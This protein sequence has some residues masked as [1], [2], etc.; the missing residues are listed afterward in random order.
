MFAYASSLVKPIEET[1]CLTVPDDRM[2]TLVDLNTRVHGNRI[3]PMEPC[4][5]SYSSAIMALPLIT[6][7]LRRL[8]HLAHGRES[9][10]QAPE[11][12]IP[13]IKVQS[14][15]DLATWVAFFG[16]LRDSRWISDDEYIRRLSQLRAN[17]H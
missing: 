16:R 5:F 3:L 14:Q 17:S 12:G 1:S 15:K 2:L 4:T 9:S 6:R 7:L 13:E 11:R 8:N 10:A